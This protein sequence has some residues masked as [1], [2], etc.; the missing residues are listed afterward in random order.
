MKDMPFSHLYVHP[1]VGFMIKTEAN[2]DM[3]EHGFTYSS[4]LTL[5]VT[6]V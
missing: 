1:H 2:A 5:F 6:L 3:L 4:P